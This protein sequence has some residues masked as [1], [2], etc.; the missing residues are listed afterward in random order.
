MRFDVR[1]L[2]IVLALLPL[3]GSSN[4]ALITTHS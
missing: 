3:S 1:C 4:C 2:L